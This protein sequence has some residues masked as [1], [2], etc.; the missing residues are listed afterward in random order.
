MSDASHGSEAHAQHAHEVFEGKP[1]DSIPPDEPHTPGWLPVVGAALLLVGIMAFALSKPGDQGETPAEAVA[2]AAAS[3]AARP[4]A[5]PPEPAA[6]D[7]P[8]RPR[9]MP[10]AGSVP[11]RLP[12]LPSGARP[13]RRPPGGAVPLPSARPR[14]APQPKPAP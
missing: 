11:M 8:Q 4:S 5:P 2:A 1:A 12:G 10:P 9:L 7:Q 14:P 6:D 3:E 13:I